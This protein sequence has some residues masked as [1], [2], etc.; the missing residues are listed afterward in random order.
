MEGF[1]PAFL[2]E[3][4]VAWI[5]DSASK[6]P[7]R[8]APLEKALQITLDKAELLP[9]I[10]LVDINPPGRPGTVL[11][12]FVEVVASDGPVTEQR[13]KAILDLIATSP[14]KYRPDDAVFVTA[15]AD[16]AA[17]P[18]RRTMHALAW[19]SFAWFLSDPERLIQ[20]HDGP[21]RPI[22]SLV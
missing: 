3:P 10:V 4:R 19:R 7:F 1:A 21:P 14:R 8:N 6:A 20:L 2:G 22:S 12:V 16:R 17:G 13:R 5:S 9:D 11:L 18:A 15:Y